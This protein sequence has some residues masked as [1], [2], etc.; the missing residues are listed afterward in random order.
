MNLLNLFKTYSLFKKNTVLENK[1]VA[2]FSFTGVGSA[3]RFVNNN[4]LSKANF[5]WH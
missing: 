2:N 5:K 1:A 3:T 4:L